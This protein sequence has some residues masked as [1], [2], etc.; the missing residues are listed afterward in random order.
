MCEIYSKLIIKTSERHHWRPSGVFFC[1]LCT[2]ITYYPGIAVADFE[3]VN[4]S[5]I[6]REIYYMIQYI[7]QKYAKVFMKLPSFLKVVVI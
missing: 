2:D 7:K 1:K 6:G 5:W 3:Q 4:L